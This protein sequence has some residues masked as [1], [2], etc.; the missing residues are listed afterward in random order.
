MKKLNELRKYITDGKEVTVEYTPLGENFILSDKV[1]INL[2]FVN[3]LEKTTDFKFNTIRRAITDEV[4]DE[5]EKLY[6]TIKTHYDDGDVGSVEIPAPMSIG[7]TIE[8]YDIKSSDDEE[9]VTMK[10]TDM[11]MMKMSNCSEEVAETLVASKQ[12]GVNGK[13]MYY[14]Y[15]SVLNI[16]TKEFIDCMMNGKNNIDHHYTYDNA[17]DSLHSIIDNT[18]LKNKVNHINK[19]TKRNL[20]IKENSVV[21]AFV[22]RI[23]TI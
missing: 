20:D 8:I 11:K 7:D 2:V 10:I 17:I 1:I 18:H 22:S 13:L 12:I 14:D 3:G 23:E 5:V 6:T 21:L 16:S 19:L 4:G 9:I 15:R